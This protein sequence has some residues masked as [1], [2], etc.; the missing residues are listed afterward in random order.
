MKAHLAPIRRPLRIVLERDEYD[1]YT[2]A[3]LR[4]E[5][6]AI[7]E[8]PVTIDF[9]RVRF[10][11]ASVFAELLR[12]YKRLRRGAGCDPQI[13]LTNVSANIRKLFDIVGLTN[14]FYFD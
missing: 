8:N 5:L 7:T 6:A 12:L 9:S 2:A 13:D 10:V 11:D 4:R 3:L 14:F 1:F